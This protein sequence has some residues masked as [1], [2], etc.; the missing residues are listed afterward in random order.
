MGRVVWTDKLAGT[1][2]FLTE[3]VVD[4]VT[5]EVSA[6]P[7]PQ[8]LAEGPWGSENGSI[9]DPYIAADGDTIGF[10]YR[11]PAGDLP[12]EDEGF[13]VF[14]ASMSGCSSST[15]IWDLLD[16]LGCSGSLST[17]F[18]E[19][20]AENG[21]FYWNDLTINDDATRIYVNQM[22]HT[23]EN[24]GNPMPSGTYV[25]DKIAG[26]WGDYSY[27]PELPFPLTVAVIDQGL[28]DGPRDVL[29]AN[30]SS[31]FN[32][33]GEVIVV[34]IENCLSAAGMCD[35]IIG[36]NILGR[37][38]SWL[39][40]DRLVFEERI[41]KRQGKNYSCKTGGMGVADP[42]DSST[43]QVHATDGGFEPLGWR[44][45]PPQP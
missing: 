35:S 4:S 42:F 5:N 43:G 3:F 36:H 8:V 1:L 12:L 30:G 11:W 17:V 16:P 32:L 24:T 2:L 31:E 41:Y 25:V 39:E 21:G 26:I 18:S 13:T 29:A 33:C 19:S 45:P 14:T 9:R 22:I 23:Q 44:R 28:G 34:D 38:P 37:R 27:V 7:D 6:S 10:L 20:S 15:V 40:D